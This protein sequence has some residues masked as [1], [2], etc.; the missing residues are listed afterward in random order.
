MA[1]TFTAPTHPARSIVTDAAA[2]VAAAVRG[3]AARRRSHRNHMLA[4]EFDDH[5]LSDMGV[6]REELCGALDA[7]AGR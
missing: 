3:D 4:R 6:T 5:M 2:W 7:C 1:M